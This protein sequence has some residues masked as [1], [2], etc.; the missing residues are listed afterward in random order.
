MEVELILMEVL[1]MEVEVELV[2]LEVDEV[3]VVK[4]DLGYWPKSMSANSLR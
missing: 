3:E 2:E 4:A 1:D